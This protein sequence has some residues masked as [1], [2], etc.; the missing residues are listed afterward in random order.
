[1]SNEIQ[2]TDKDRIIE[3]LKMEYEMQ[4]AEIR[5]LINAMDLNLNMGV[6]F[7]GVLVAAYATFNGRIEILYVIPSVIYVVISIHVVKVASAAVHGTYCHAIEKRYRELLSVDNESKKEALLDFENGLA[8]F[9][10]EPKYLTQQ[11][12]YAVFGFF[13]VLFFAVCIIV[14]SQ[15]HNAFPGQWYNIFVCWNKFIFWLN[16]IHIAEIVVMIFLLMGIIS[17]NPPAS[18]KEY[19]GLN[20]EK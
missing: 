4:R 9:V 2:N 6:G 7:L 1:M 15:L 18:L 8:K 5:D 14:F 20:D 16:I 10:G 12:I 13:L 11:G 19:L 17:S 3:S